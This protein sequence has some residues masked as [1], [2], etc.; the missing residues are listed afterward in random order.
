M[1]AE[2]VGKAIY[3]LRKKVGL[4]QKELADCLDVTDKAVSKWERGLSVPDISIVSKLSLLLNTDI[5]NLLE[6]NITYLDHNWKGVLLLDDQ[7]KDVVPS[8]M[9]HGKPLVYILL[10][11]FVLN[12]IRD[13]TL[14]GSESMLKNAAATLPEDPSVW[15]C[16]LQFE[17]SVK[18]I[19]ERK[20]NTMFVFGNP[21]FF[22]PN[23]TKYFQ[24][25][26]SVYPGPSILLSPLPGSIN[27]FPEGS[28]HTSLYFESDHVITLEAGPDSLPYQPLPFLFCP[29]RYLSS[30]PEELHP[31]S[32]DQDLKELIDDKLLYAE[33]IGRGMIYTGVHSL[34]DVL[35]VSCFIRMQE[36][37]SGY[38]LYEMEEIARRRLLH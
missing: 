6:G 36:K 33:P 16:S 38:A 37:T 12:G 20:E 26:M 23:V 14:V 3:T 4:T 25:A 15:G 32:L 31:E 1:D 21:F 27:R 5:D 13:I 24:R 2:K 7:A 18:K 8:T 17:T 29:A 30:L 11:Y 10:C 28:E 22:G 34:D 35:D 19:L 9:L